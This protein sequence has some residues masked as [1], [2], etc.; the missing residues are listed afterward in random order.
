MILDRI[1]WQR[2]S[3][4]PS[5]TDSSGTSASGIFVSLG[6]ILFSRMSDVS[7][8]ELLT[9]GRLATAPLFSASPQGLISIM[10]S[11]NAEQSCQAL[12]VPTIRAL[13]C[14]AGCVVNFC[15]CEIPQLACLLNG[16]LT[17]VEFAVSKVC[18]F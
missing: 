8:D 16:L 15:F 6:V 3:T 7:H 14:G 17:Q 2:F 12:R 11:R 9:A 4:I 18:F 5:M 10:A 1:D 13:A